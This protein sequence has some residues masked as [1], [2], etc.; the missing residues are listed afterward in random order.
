M[1]HTNPCL[2]KMHHSAKEGSFDDSVVQFP[3]S[4]LSSWIDSQ[5]LLRVCIHDGD[6]VLLA[7]GC[8]ELGVPLGFP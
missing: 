1:C 4:P 3:I 7:G 2:V 5:V 8:V 6:V